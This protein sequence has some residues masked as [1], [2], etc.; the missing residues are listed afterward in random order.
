VLTPDFPIGTERLLLRPLVTADV[1]AL[2]A[3]QSRPD[4]CRYIP[5]EPRTKEQIAERIADVD[6]RNRSV[7]DQAGQALNLGVVLR[8]TGELVGDVMLFWH[9]AEHRAGEIGYVF[10]PD[11]A[12]NGYATEAGRALLEL[13]FDGLGLH[14]VVGRIDARNDASGAVLKRLGMRQEALL[15]ENEWFKGEWSSEIV[16]A[17][18]ETEWRGRPAG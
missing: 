2:H 17:I 15:V 6:G 16:F 14:R 18:L 13:A 7:L 10:H 11:H 4:V 5:Y 8:T 3:Y 12:G 1:G 9:S